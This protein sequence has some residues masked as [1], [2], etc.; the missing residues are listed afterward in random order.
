LETIFGKRGDLIAAS[1]IVYDRKC[2]CL[3]FEV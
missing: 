3:T 2:A 1:A